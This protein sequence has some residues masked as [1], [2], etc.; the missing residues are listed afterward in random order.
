[1]IRSDTA[2]APAFPCPCCQ[3]HEWSPWRQIRE[4]AL[5]R[6]PRCGLV[7]WDFSQRNLLEI[8]REG[9]FDSDTASV[10]YADYLSM[11]E[12][13]RENAKKRLRRLAR[14]R[15]DDRRDFVHDPPLL[16]EVGCAHGFFLDE[17]R[18][19]GYRVRGVEPAEDASGHAR[20]RLKLDVLTG[21]LEALELPP[22]SVDIIVLWDVIE[23]VDQPRTVLE[24]CRTALRPGGTIALSTG[25]VASAVSHLQG[26]S[27]HLYNLPEHL[28][29]FTPEVLRRLLTT[30]DFERVETRHPSCVYPVRYLAERL[31][32]TAWPRWAWKRLRL[33]RVVESWQLPVNLWDVTEV[34]ARRRLRSEG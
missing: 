14:T 2:P 23:H 22:E 15:G 17:A 13:I 5:Y 7:S 24:Q 27:W 4:F 10:G 21:T 9:Y 28:F 33:P 30:L 32:R 1:M 6:C 18:K 19:A 31:S 16:V 34:I 20:E 26:A 29:F 12:T 11:E 25:N 3:V 8:Y